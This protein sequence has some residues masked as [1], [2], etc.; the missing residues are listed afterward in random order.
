MSDKI[1]HMQVFFI[2]LFVNL[3]SC[4]SITFR[5]APSDSI[6][7]FNPVE[8]DKPEEEL[9]QKIITPPTPPKAKLPEVMTE[10]F[11]I[12]SKDD[13]EI[14]LVVDTSTS[15]DDNLQKIGDNIQSMLSYIKT[16]NWRMAFT[17]A[18]HGDHTSSTSNESWEDYTGTHPR[19]GKLMSLEHNKTILNEFILHKEMSLY[20][21]IFKDTITREDPSD[22]DLPPYCQEGNEQPLRAMQATF[23]RYAVDSQA[24][25]FF[26]PDTDTIALI[27]TDE[28]ERRE[29][30]ENAT[31]ATE[32]LH[33]YNT[34][35]NGQNK[36]LFGFSISIQDAECYDREIKN[37]GFLG[38]LR[39]NRSAD[40]GYVIGQLANLTG[41]KNISLCSTDYSTVLSQISQ[42]TQHLVDSSVTLEKMF[43]VPNSVQVAL[44]P[45]QPDIT[46]QLL[47]RKIV[48]SMGIKPK[49]KVKVT[50]KYENL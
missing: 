36:R 44:L 22:C 38:F 42:F 7:V 45:S 21:N 32:V 35:F 48:F 16:K 14:L 31:T 26:R 18:D 20:E 13:L 43:Y 41:G 39:P 33:T 24:Q 15:M 49:T 50:Y 47:G 34:I 37:D 46:W 23:S 12:S 11:V 28:D 8:L 25:Q 4:N 6:T 1:I 10:Y 27:I 2:I 29:D 40:Y 30:H 19:F 9:S 5:S 3:I 17:T